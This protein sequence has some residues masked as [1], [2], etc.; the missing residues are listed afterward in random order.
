[1]NQGEIMLGLYGYWCASIHSIA[2]HA[3][4]QSGNGVPCILPQRHAL[5]RIS[6]IYCLKDM[7]QTNLNKRQS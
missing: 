4:I 6:P 3:Q 7:A 1:M 2:L 5:Q